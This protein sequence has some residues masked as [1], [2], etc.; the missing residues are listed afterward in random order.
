MACVHDPSSGQNGHINADGVIEGGSTQTA[1]RFI[2]CRSDGNR[3]A[4]EQEGI[5]VSLEQTTFCGKVC[6]VCGFE[7]RMRGNVVAKSEGK[8]RGA[9]E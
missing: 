1:R 5:A 3:F 7:P 2:S 4:K 9:A 8:A 6:Y